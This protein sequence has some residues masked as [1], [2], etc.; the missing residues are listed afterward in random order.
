MVP[1]ANSCVPKLEFLQTIAP[2]A[3]APVFY[4]TCSTSTG[5]GESTFQVAQCFNSS[6]LALGG[7]FQ[8][9]SPY[10]GNVVQSS[11]SN[12][13]PAGWEAMLVNQDGAD[14]TFTVCVS[15]CTGCQ[16]PPPPPPP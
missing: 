6:D 2:P 16:S 3:A 11:F 7:G 8:V 12:G 14:E 9:S 4:S 13:S 5:A 1:N 10:T 15:C